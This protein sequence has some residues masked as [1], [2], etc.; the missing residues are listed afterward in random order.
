MLAANMERGQTG[1]GKG[2]MDWSG[3]EKSRANHFAAYE[4][5]VFEVFG[6]GREK[7]VLTARGWQDGPLPEEDLIIITAYNPG[8]EW[9][10]ESVNR[11]RNQELRAL[12]LRSKL[13]FDEALGRN[14]DG[15]HQ[16]PSFA[17]RLEEGKQKQQIAFVSSLGGRFGQAGLFFWDC[18]SRTGATLWLAG[19]IET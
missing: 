18:R 1:P 3:F 7:T 19:S 12:L 6:P 5:A 8:M 2:G 4:E 13:S 10:E 14:L 15:S 17:V 9:P 16:E 11:Q